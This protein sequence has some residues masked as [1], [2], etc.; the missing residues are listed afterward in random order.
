MQ[1]YVNDNTQELYG[2]FNDVSEGFA[3]LQGFVEDYFTNLDVQEEIDNKLDAMAL[4]GSLYSII[5]PV[6][7][8]ALQ[9]AIPDAVEDW[10]DENMTTTEPILDY[11]LSIEDAAA[12]SRTSGDNFKSDR[13]LIDEVGMFVDYGYGSSMLGAEENPSAFE[14]KVGIKRRG[15]LV[16]LSGENDTSDA[17]YARMSGSLVRASNTST[18]QA[19]DSGFTLKNNH[20]YVVKVKLISGSV[21]NSNLLYPKLE[22]YAVGSSTDL[23]QHRTM[24][25]YIEQEFELSGSGGQINL[26]WHIYGNTAFNDAE[27][28]VTVEDVTDGYTTESRVNNMITERSG[29]IIDDAAE[30]ANAVVAPTFSTS[31]AYSVGDYVMYHGALCMFTSSHSAGAWNANEVSET[32]VAENLTAKNYRIGGELSVTMTDGKF[33]QSNSQLADNASSSASDFIP[34]AVGKKYYI[35]NLFLTGTRCLVAYNR[36]SASTVEVIL[37]GTTITETEY[38]VPSGVTHIRGTAK[39]GEKIGVYLSDAFSSIESLETAVKENQTAIDE[40]TKKTETDEVKSMFPADYY[41]TGIIEKYPFPDVAFNDIGVN[42]YSDGRS[43]FTDYKPS[44]HKNSG[45]TTYYIRPD[46]ANQNDGLTP[47]TAKRHIPSTQA[48]GDTYILMDG[49][50]GR[51]VFPTI[52]KSVNIIAQNSGKAICVNSDNSYTYTLVEGTTYSAERSNVVSVLIKIGDDYTALKGVISVAVCKSTPFSFYSDTSLVYVNTGGIIVPDNTNCFL[53]LSLAKP[54]LSVLAE[55]ENINVYIEGIV[56]IGGSCGGLVAK[57]SA[58]YTYQ[59]HAYKCKF[60]GACK[61]TQQN[62]DAVSC[63]GGKGYF[64][65]CEAS[66]AVK[67]GFNYHAYNSEAP[68]GIEI[69]CIGACNG[70]NGDNYTNNGSTAHEGGVVIRING[71]YHD[72]IGANVADVHTDTK[73]LN[74]RCIAYD[75][76]GDTAQGSNADFSTQQA[77]AIMWLDRCKTVGESQYSIYAYSGTEMHLHKCEYI[78]AQGAGTIDTTWNPYA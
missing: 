30:L 61:T 22:A 56:L 31:Q 54:F 59:V 12:E 13:L 63:L 43:F 20:S 72:N 21:V 78:N 6:V 62:Y 15:S 37:T 55:N 58:S 19:W 32:D 77:T 45:G 39:H 14:R 34:V 2:A 51:N 17:C 73:T 18:I 5:Y 42:V 8:D 49:Y 53:N 40:R 66:H 69:D 60:M 11:T 1:D 48:D 68:K 16:T 52:N 57:N 23:A 65:E 44:A 76:H 25:T 35:N 41:G 4:D 75:S 74:L 10:L 27:Y 70:R 50:H 67:D 46:G 47:E 29:D 71:V 38:T 64:V 26:C 9:T 36:Q 7:D 28:L 3:T 24:T 33:V